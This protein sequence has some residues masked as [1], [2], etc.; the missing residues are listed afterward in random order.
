MHEEQPFLSEGDAYPTGD[1]AVAKPI[2]KLTKKKPMPQAVHRR[3]W[4]TPRQEEGLPSFFELFRI[5]LQA[6]PKEQN[7]ETD[8]G[9]GADIGFASHQPQVYLRTD[10][11]PR[12]AT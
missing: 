3:N 12:R 11:Y 5:D 2:A 10:E 7:D 9:D 6:N 8:F 4:T 1:G